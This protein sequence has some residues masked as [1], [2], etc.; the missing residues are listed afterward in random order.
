MHLLMKVA[1]V[2]ALLT[3]FASLG[4]LLLLLTLVLSQTE[5]TRTEE[6]N[7]LTKERKFG[8]DLKIGSPTDALSSVSKDLKSPLWMSLRPRTLPS[9]LEKRY[10][11]RGRRKC[12]GGVF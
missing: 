7:T 11:W 4:L 8:A 1:L 10:S 9:T 3:G 12:E 6:L 5:L 2:V